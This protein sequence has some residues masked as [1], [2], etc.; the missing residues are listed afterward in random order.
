[1]NILIEIKFK[2]L[3]LIK[4]L[5]K[6]EAAVKQAK[7]INMITNY[8]NSLG[9]ILFKV[10][11]ICLLIKTLYHTLNRRSLSLIIKNY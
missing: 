9:P 10:N 3:S 8:A 1:M 5:I 6:E 2:N 7:V 4:L 11:K